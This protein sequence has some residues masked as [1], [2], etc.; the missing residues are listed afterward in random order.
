MQ[1]MPRL[2]KERSCSLLLIGLG[3]HCLTDEPMTGV[4]L[5]GISLILQVSNRILIDTQG[6]AHG[7]TTPSVENESGA[8]G[9]V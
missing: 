2:L 7:E 5:H 4:Q 1:A 9:I 3:R 6:T 8:I